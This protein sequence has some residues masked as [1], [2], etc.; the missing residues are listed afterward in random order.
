M[1]RPLHMIGRRFL[2]VPYVLGDEMDVRARADFRASF[3]AEGA[4][5]PLGPKWTLLDGARVRAIGGVE[6]IAPGCWALWAYAGDL[7]AREWVFGARCAG[8]VAAWLRT[9][10]DFKALQVLPAEGDAA[11]RLVKHIG[12]KFHERRGWRDLY[13]MKE[14]A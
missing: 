10:P 3:A 8:K 11:A 5:L 13:V 9:L 6:Q 12:F 1:R 2:A 4:R 14:A 7:T